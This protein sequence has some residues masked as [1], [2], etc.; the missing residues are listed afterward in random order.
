MAFGRGDGSVKALS[1][2]DNCVFTAHQDRRIRVW[3]VSR[4]QSKNTFRLIA[5]LPTKRDY[6]G[7]FCLMGE[8][9]CSGS[10][11]R[12]IGIWKREG[13]GGRGFVRLGSISGHEGHVKC[14]QGSA[15]T[16]RGGFLLYG[17]LEFG[18]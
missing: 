15:Y 18:G 7:R 10:A 12:T 14:L 5:T 16:V 4:G 6:L 9:M 3:E 1:S 11:N 2:V 13:D 17:G 8:F